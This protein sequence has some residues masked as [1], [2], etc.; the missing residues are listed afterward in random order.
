M[1]RT[2]ISEAIEVQWIVGRYRERNNI[3]LISVRKTNDAPDGDK[4]RAAKR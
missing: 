1:K 4:V 2:A 3:K